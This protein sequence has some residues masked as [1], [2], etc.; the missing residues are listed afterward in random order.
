MM[1]YRS[2]N[3]LDFSLIRQGYCTDIS[4][5]YPPLVTFF[6]QTEQILRC[7]VKRGC[8]TR[9][10]RKYPGLIIATLRQECLPVGCISTAVV[11]ATRSQYQGHFLFGPMFFLGPVYD[12]TSCLV[13]YAFWGVSV[14]GVSLPPF[15]CEQTD[16][17][18]NI[19]FPCGR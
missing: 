2:A 17:C 1:Q 5:Q 11:A 16:R 6:G 19:T 8:S 4:T 13:L 14:R 3:N 15:P 10:E 12:V 7:F 18:K 9:D